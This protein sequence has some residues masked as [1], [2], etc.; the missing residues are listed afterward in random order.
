MITKRNWSLAFGGLLTLLALLASNPA[1]ALTV[2]ADNEP[3]VLIKVHAY[4]MDEGD[5][6]VAMRAALES[7]HGIYWDLIVDR[8]R[9]CYDTRILMSEKKTFTFKVTGEISKPFIAF[10]RS[11][12]VMTG[13]RGG[14][15]KKG[16]TWAAADGRCGE[17]V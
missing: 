11:C 16:F 17:G 9:T 3:T 15:G 7:D 2:D 12:L 8:D 14:G 4:C 1:V 10:D 6:R 5:N 13:F